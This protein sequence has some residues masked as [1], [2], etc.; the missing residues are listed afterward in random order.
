MFGFVTK[1]CVVNDIGEGNSQDPLIRLLSQVICD[2]KQT[3]N[4]WQLIKWLKI[5][6]VKLHKEAN[7]YSH[8]R[9]RVGSHWWH[10][11]TVARDV[12]V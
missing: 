4:C 3:Q 8:H 5:I 9:Q 12:W 6:Q 7:N 1:T 2:P 10:E 11:S